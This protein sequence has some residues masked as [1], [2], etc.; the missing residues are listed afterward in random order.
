[1]IEYEDE[2][3][4]INIGKKIKHRKLADDKRYQH[5]EDTHKPKVKK[6]TITKMLTEHVSKRDI[7]LGIY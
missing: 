5:K 6:T 4:D 3:E 7:D 2:R 1:M